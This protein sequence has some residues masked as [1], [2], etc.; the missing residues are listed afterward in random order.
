MQHIKHLEEKFGV[1]CHTISVPRIEPA[2]GSEMS[3]HPPYAVSD[4]DFCKVV[5]IL[6]LAVPYTGMIM[7]T[8]E[9]PDM[10]RETFALGVS[11]ISAGSRTNPGGYTGAEEEDMS[12]FSLG[13]HRG[14]DEVIQD[15][16]QLGYIPSFCTACYR[17]GRTGA[18][19]MDLAKPG[20]IKNF[21][22]INAL[23]TFAEYLEDYASPKTKEIG[24]AKIGEILNAM[25][26]AR[27]KRAE[28]LLNRVKA[29]ERDVYV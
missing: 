19:F 5:A 22:E 26:E 18:D 2:V 10:R 7:T 21:C 9:T 28:P 27:K 3:L 17:L 23:N 6:R 4:I 12:Q 15:I 13:D 1:G 20:L 8:R 11:Q 16:A 24:W 25:T 14:P 29:G